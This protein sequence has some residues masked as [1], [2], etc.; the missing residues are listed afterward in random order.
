MEVTMK[1]QKPVESP[2]DV[3]CADREIAFPAELFA[4]GVGRC[5]F[6]KTFRYGAGVSQN[7]LFGN[8][9]DRSV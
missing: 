7:Q 3:C 4:T 2:I 9:I 8:H 6:S 5:V 1:F